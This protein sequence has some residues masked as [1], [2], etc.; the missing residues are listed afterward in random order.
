M[1]QE[2]SNMN[3]EVYKVH[4]DNLYR[5]SQYCDNH[6][7][8]RRSQILEYFGELFD[9][10]KC[11]ENKQTLCDNCTAF[12]TNAFKLKDITAEAI[13]IIKGIREL[14]GLDVTLLHVSEILKGSMNVKVVEKQHNHLE[15]HGKLSQY[16]KNDIERVIRRLIFD[17]YLKEDVKI[18]QHT[19]TVA[20]Y[21]KIGAK[22][23]S[24]LNGQVKIEF[25]L[26]SNDKASQITD[27]DGD[28]CSDDEN[29]NNN[30]AGSG[31]S[32]VIKPPKA[33]Q[34][35]KTTKQLTPGINK[36]SYINKNGEMI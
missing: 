14:N 9:R 4:L 11:I 15:M 23:S 27:E 36:A 17:G 5:M 7:D 12:T 24:L 29:N 33:K 28:E 2:Q 19:D 22:A 26:R 31:S 6:T 35:S 21:I 32:K 25:D 1:K 34:I 8:C 30:C 10:K 18:L 16:K 13:S 20:S 3:Y